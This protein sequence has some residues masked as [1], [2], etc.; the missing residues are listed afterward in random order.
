MYLRHIKPLFVFGLALILCCLFTNCSSEAKKLSTTDGISIE[1]DE[2]HEKEVVV[3][4]AGQTITT[5]ASYYLD[6]IKM[7]DKNGNRYLFIRLT[8]GGSCGDSG[9]LVTVMNGQLISYD[10][11]GN[12][13]GGWQVIEPNKI[14]FFKNWMDICGLDW[15]FSCGPSYPVMWTI[16]DCQN[17]KI[18]ARRYRDLKELYSDNDGKI[19]VDKMLKELHQKI[20][21]REPQEPFSALSNPVEKEFCTRVAKG[22]EGAQIRELL[23]SSDFSIG[24]RIYF[25]KETRNNIGSS[26]KMKH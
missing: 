14:V 24:D 16:D 2:H 11:E 22:E 5:R 19:L 8:E 20:T 23:F 15:C 4:Y 18:V 21:A 26:Q 25:F 3:R 17:S 1:Q 12:P 6:T 10:F 7:H 13:C 9:L